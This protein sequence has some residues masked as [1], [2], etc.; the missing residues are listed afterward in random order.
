MKKTIFLI[1]FVLYFN[2]KSI[3]EPYNSIKPLPL[4]IQGDFSPENRFFLE[5]FIKEF[6]VEVVLE[7]GVSYGKPTIFMGK[8]L[9]N[10]GK[11]YAIDTWKAYSEDKKLVDNKV[12]CKVFHQ[13]LS[14]VIHEGLT[15]TII[16]I[17][18]SC[19]EAIRAL[20]IYP[21]LIYIDGSHFYEDLYG[22]IIEWE[23][24]NK[25]AIICGDNWSDEKI[26][27]EVIKAAYQ[28]GHVILNK[29]SFWYLEPKKN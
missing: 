17:R 28:L 19:N 2:I 6:D 20:N 23:K 11:I 22:D 25:N 7:I 24:L 15:D 4:D 5:K 13:F 3:C 14:N 27:K 12:T 8:L 9:K 26:K 16:P 21:D 29:G 18:M 1:L 10:K